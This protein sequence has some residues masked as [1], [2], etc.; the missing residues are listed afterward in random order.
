MWRR[1][2]STGPKN[3]PE[4]PGCSYP[5]VYRLDRSWG[6]HPPCSRIWWTSERTV[7]FR[8][9]NGG[10][11][12]HFSW[13]SGKITVRRVHGKRGSAQFNTPPQPSAFNTKIH[14]LCCNPGNKRGGRRW[15]RREIISPI[16]DS[17]TKSSGRIKVLIACP[18]IPIG[19][20]RAI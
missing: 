4:R 17:N 1:R 8:L 10:I 12:H 2:I 16:S 15:P 11:G 19:S 9:R 3:R 20:F 14:E 7:I 5:G 6:F 18:N 13:Q